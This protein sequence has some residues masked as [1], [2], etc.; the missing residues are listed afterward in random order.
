[1]KIIFADANGLADNDE[2]AIVVLNITRQE[3]EARN[4]ASVLERLHVLTDSRENVIRY[5]ESVVFQVE[6]YDDDPREL[7]EIPEVRNYFHALAAE[8]PHWIWF[9]HRGIG[10]VALLFALLCE[11]SVLRGPGNQRATA[12]KNTAEMQAVMLD[13]LARGMAL[14]DTYAIARKELDDSAMSVLVELNFTND[15]AS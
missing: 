8:W 12:F 15:Q 1:M 9:L 5:R 3:I 13:L 2:P 6:G 7:Q 11:V 14:L 4:I 10:A